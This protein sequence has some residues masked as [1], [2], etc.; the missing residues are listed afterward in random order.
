METLGQTFDLISIENRIGLQHTTTFVGFFA[1]VG[2]FDFLGVALVE[3]G[4]GGFFTF[5]HLRAQFFGL[6]V[7]HPERR[8]VT[9][10]IGNHPEPE[11]IHAA[12]R[13][14]ARA[15]WA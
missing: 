7:G 4:D 2:C 8:G 6:I 12:I 10:H 14:A 11:N 5:A 1:G 15:Q 13:D 9:A 3:D